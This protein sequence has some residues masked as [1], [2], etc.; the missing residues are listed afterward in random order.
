MLVG[1]LYGKRYFWIQVIV[2]FLFIVGVI[3]VVW[4]DLQIKVCWDG[5]L[6]FYGY[7][8]EVNV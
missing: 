3:I 5:L 4:F 2:V 1:S 8:Y 6:G 7:E